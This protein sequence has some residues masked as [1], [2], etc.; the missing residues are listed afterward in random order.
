MYK[1]VNIKGYNGFY[2]IDTNGNMYS[3]HIVGPHK[4]M[5][6]VWK[7][8]KLK[9]TRSGHKL[10]GL[11]KEHKITECLVHRLVL[12]TFVGSCP[13]SMECRHLDSNPANNKLSNLKW[14]TRA[15]NENDKIANGTSNHGERNG[16]AK[17]T[18]KVVIEIRE[19]YN[20]KENTILELSNLYNITKR[21][22]S[23]IIKRETWKHI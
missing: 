8:L 23:R 2:Q 19:K 1:R 22:V 7:K 4:N 10:V 11:C 6:G 16:L 20:N 15:E 13:D 14:G 21:H 9:T 17:I 5:K 12:K 18:S 3:C